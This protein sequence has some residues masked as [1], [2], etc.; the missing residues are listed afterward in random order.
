VPSNICEPPDTNAQFRRIN[1]DG[2]GAEVF[3]RGVRNSVGFD[4]HPITKD[5]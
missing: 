1:R 5:F 4:W 2:R 3:A